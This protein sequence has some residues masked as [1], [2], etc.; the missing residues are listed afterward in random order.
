MGGCL[1]KGSEKTSWTEEDVRLGIMFIKWRDVGSSVTLL[2]SKIRVSTSGS[3]PAWYGVPHLRKLHLDNVFMYHGGHST[4]GTHHLAS[5][6]ISRLRI[7][8]SYMHKSR[9]RISLCN[10]FHT[11]HPF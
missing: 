10:R 9:K 6:N 7:K 1:R 2:L 5:I 8:P 4:L 3:M 11:K